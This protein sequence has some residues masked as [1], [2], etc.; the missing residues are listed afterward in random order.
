MKFFNNVDNDRTAIVKRN[1]F[2]SFGIKG[3]SVLISFALVPLTIGYVSSELYGVWLTLSSILAW[4]SFLDI[5]LSQGLKNKLT[6]AIAQGNWKKGK[7]LVSTTYFTMMLIF[8]PLC[9]VLEVI[10]P[11]ISWSNLLNVN[12]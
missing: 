4:L 2:A 3:I 8:F 6:E 11:L 1:V 5:G 12:A 9:I 7:S 10:V